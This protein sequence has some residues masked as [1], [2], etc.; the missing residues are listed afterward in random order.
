MIAM[1]KIL[2]RI[3]LAAATL[4]SLPLHAHEF[5]F[6]PV[7]APLVAGD[8][9]RLDLRVGQFFVGDQLGFFG[10]QTVALQL[11]TAAGRQDLRPALP[12]PP[13]GALRTLDLQL[14]D[15][16]TYMVAFDSQPSQIALSAGRFEAYLH[17]EGLDFI[18]AQRDATGTSQAPGRE[19]Y[20]RHIKTLLHVSEA[21]GGTETSSPK[22]DKLYALRTGQ[23]LEIVPANDPLAMKPGD[24]LGLQVWFDDK[25]LAGALLKAWN[26]H[27]GQ[28]VIIR[29]TTSADG[30]ASVNLP[31]AGG[32][33]VS[34]VHMVPAL[35]VKDIDW[36]SLWGNLSFTLAPAVSL[37]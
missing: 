5:W 26:K 18:K 34:V 12:G 21:P 3:A 29:T 11:F 17:D 20:R 10:P 31:Y 4:A 22:P 8:T 28:T 35:G 13:R 1:K 7:T 25:P 16:G 23:R 9:A 36:D 33:M 15:A 24:N 37:R 32:W 6:E 2:L 27:D 14:K 30:K 19:R